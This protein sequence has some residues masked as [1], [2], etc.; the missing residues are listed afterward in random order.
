MPRLS[1][2][3]T[4]TYGFILAAFAAVSAEVLARI[5]DYWEL[6][7][8][9]LATPGYDDLIARDE[10]GA[11][12]SP[13]GRYRDIRL[14]SGG[15][16][17]PESALADSAG[18]VRVMTLGA[19]E[20]LGTGSGAPGN[21]YP[22]QLGDTL[23]KHGCYRVLNAGMVGVSLPSLIPFWNYWGARFHPDVVV[24]LTSPSLYLGD[25]PPRRPGTLPAGEP[26]AAPGIPP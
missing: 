25:V 22:A 21:E 16:R 17:S 19:S 23:S 4:L 14:N 15:F 3:K 5:D 9:L 24:V 7:I 26:P 18:C 13:N 1:L 6:R 12:G 11:H 8:P 2:A 10:F 20:T